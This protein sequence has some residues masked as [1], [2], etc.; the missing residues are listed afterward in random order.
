M[1][2]IA[3]DP[4]LLLPVQSVL[5]Q[6]ALQNQTSICRIPTPTYG[7]EQED[8]EESQEEDE[9]Y[10]DEHS[11]EDEMSGLERDS[12]RAMVAQRKKSFFSLPKKNSARFDIPQPLSAPFSLLPSLFLPSNPSPRKCHSNQPHVHSTALLASSEVYSKD[13]S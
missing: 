11:G 2:D 4:L 8:E 6:A 12:P 3:C 9:S 5:S 10:E 7:E 1:H 13:C